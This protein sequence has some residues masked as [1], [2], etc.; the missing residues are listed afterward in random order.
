[1]EYFAIRVALINMFLGFHWCIF[2]CNQQ[3]RFERPIGAVLTVENWKFGCL[4]YLYGFDNPGIA[5]VCQVCQSHGPV[6]RQAQHIYAVCLRMIG[7]PGLPPF[8]NQEFVFGRLCVFLRDD[9]QFHFLQ[10]I[11]GTDLA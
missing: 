4:Y 7:L 3:Q 2:F 1:M 5:W 6:K 11:E 8:A 10:D 9:D